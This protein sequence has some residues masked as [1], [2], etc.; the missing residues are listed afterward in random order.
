M[1]RSITIILW[2]AAYTCHAQPVA[3]K[4]SF[5]AIL[6]SL[7]ASLVGKPYPAFDITTVDGSH[8]SSDT[9]KGK[10][11]FIS[12]WFEWCTPCRAEFPAFNELYNNKKNNKDFVFIAA[13]YETPNTIERIRKEHHLQYPLASISKAECERLKL[14]GGYPV[15]IIVDK[16]GRIAAYHLAGS[17]DSTKAKAFYSTAWLSKI[18]SLLQH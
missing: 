17:A 6:D 14:A 3:A 1:K 15:N 9:T 11:L 4:R 16:A 12:F 2:L 10:V 5:S 8:I 7:S 13:T 18:D